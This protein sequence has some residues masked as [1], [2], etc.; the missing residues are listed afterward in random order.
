MNDFM[1]ER[2]SEKIDAIKDAKNDI[3]EH[4]KLNAPLQT[5]IDNRLNI[6]KEYSRALALF[7]GGM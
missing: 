2:I 3:K 5:Y 1:L 4:K 6:I 7:I